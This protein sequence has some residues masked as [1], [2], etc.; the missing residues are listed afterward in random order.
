VIV[1]SSS[2]N[3]TITT[4]KFNVNGA[5]ST[6]RGVLKVNLA[7]KSFKVTSN[8]TS[9]GISLNSVGRY[10]AQSPAWGNPS[11][12]LI[13]WS[14]SEDGKAI[15]ASQS[16]AAASSFLLLDFS[17]LSAPLDT[18]HHT[19]S[20]DSGLSFNLSMNLNHNITAKETIHDP[21]APFSGLFTAGFSHKVQI[22]IPGSPT[23]LGDELI[24]NSGSLLTE[25]MIALSIA[26]P[27]VG[28][29][30]FFTERRLTSPSRARTSR[31]KNRGK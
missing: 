24:I 22:V 25:T 27:I 3:T 5:T 1:S 19:L 2:L 17:Q 6:D 20:V 26:V 15:T 31:K 14:Y 9:S 23:V 13:A 10:I 29:V 11:N 7:W 16:L 30:T 28:V 4:V 21:T 18:W 8:I 12:S